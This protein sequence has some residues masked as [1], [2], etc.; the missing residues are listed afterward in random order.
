MNLMQEG[1]F[2]RQDLKPRPPKYETRE[3]SVLLFRELYFYN[4]GREECVGC[5]AFGSNVTRNEVL[6]LHTESFHEHA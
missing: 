1:Q 6:D 2:P 4:I 3:C 5:L